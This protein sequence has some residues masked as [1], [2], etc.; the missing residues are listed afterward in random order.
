MIALLLG[1]ML[2]NITSQFGLKQIEKEPIHT[3]NDLPSSIGLIF[4]SHPNLITESEVHPL[5]HPICHHQ[6][7]YAK[8]NS[9]IYYSLQYF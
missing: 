9:Q 4:T 7:I 8:F 6:I 5:L 2:D 1:E 3:L